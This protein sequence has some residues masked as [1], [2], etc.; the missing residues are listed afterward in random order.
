MEK[1]YAWPRS[2][3]YE[4]LTT[5]CMNSGSIQTKKLERFRIYK[6]VRNDF[7]WRRMEKMPNIGGWR[8]LNVPDMTYPIARYDG[9]AIQ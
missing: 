8:R 2:L 6:S 7:W 3:Q 4:R 5:N 1:Q 9:G